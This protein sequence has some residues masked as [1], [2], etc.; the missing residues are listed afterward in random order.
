MAKRKLG[1]PPHVT[2]EGPSLKK[3][4]AAYEKYRPLLMSNPAV[5]RV[6]YGC[7]RTE[8][9]YGFEGEAKKVR[10]AVIVFVA[11]KKKVGPHDEG[12]IPATLDGV[13][14]DVLA[15]VPVLIR[16]AST[17]GGAAV[18]VEGGATIT[19]SRKKLVLKGTVGVV[20]KDNTTDELFALT[21]SHVACGPT[22]QSVQGDVLTVIVNATQ[23]TLGSAVRNG[24]SLPFGGTVDAAA[25]PIV[26]P[27]GGTRALIPAF[28]R[29]VSRAVE[30]LSST[31]VE[32][33]SKVH[34]RVVGHLVD[35]HA[36]GTLQMGP[37][38][39]GRTMTNLL[40]IAPVPFGE[41]GDSGSVVVVRVGARF[42]AVGLFIGVSKDNTVAFALRL[43]DEVTLDGVTIDD[44]VLTRLKVLI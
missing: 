23:V 9:R 32:M 2:V 28:G 26:S 24:F 31:A 17:E 14:T 5:T 19:L 11:I 4:R 7:K 29:V 13:P 25:V 40:A 35:V 22:V 18:A 37:G 8:G 27:G 36:T 1:A 38:G 15:D 6:S 12:Y 20:V 39:V 43:E 21:C 33:D 44:G 41:G 16:R 30:D 42:A 34:G 3:V 10:Y